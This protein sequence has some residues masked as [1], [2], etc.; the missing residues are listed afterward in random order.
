MTVIGAPVPIPNRSAMLVLGLI[1]VLLLIPAPAAAGWANANWFWFKQVISKPK[2]GVSLPAVSAASPPVMPVV[3]TLNHTVNIVRQ[4]GT[5][6]SY[7]I[8]WVS[9]GTPPQKLRWVGVEGQEISGSL[10]YGVFGSIA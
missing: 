7:W 8:G 6:A 1:S 3:V 2:P 9:V 5:A 10:L 4:T